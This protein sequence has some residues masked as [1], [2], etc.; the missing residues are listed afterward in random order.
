MKSLFDV[1][2]RPLITEKANLDK[3]V[4][5][6]YHFE[7]PVTVDRQEIKEAVEKVFQVHVEDVRTMVVRGKEK[8]MGRFLG[9]KPSWKK[10]IV[11][12]RE[13]DKIDLFEGI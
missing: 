7:V 4:H 11:T 12:L 13:G 5:N 6:T 10:A 9:R 2:R 1:I 8:R 3:E